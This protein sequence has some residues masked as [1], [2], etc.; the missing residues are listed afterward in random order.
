MKMKKVLSLTGVF[1]FSLIFVSSVLAASSD[2]LQKAT[3]YYERN[4]TGNPDRISRSRAILCYLSDKVH[5]LDTAV[6][7]VEQEQ[8]NQANLLNNLQS[9]VTTNSTDITTLKGRKS[10]IDIAQVRGANWETGATDTNV[11][12]P[13][14]VTVNCPEGCILWVNYD[15]DTRNPN[16]SIAQSSWPQHLYH[17]YVDGVNQAVFNQASMIVAN[18]A[19]PLAVN[20]V[21]S[22]GAG[23]HT[24]TIY[25][26]TTGGTLQQ[27]E[28]HLQVLAIK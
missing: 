23:E 10:I 21:F 14:H 13:D 5:E 1:V 4:C 15:V 24:V 20:G 12:T 27:F 19:I 3:E 17:I 26:R 9:N 28:S 25:A 11:E 2:F 6:S 16:G 7:N 22:V 18:A 8:T